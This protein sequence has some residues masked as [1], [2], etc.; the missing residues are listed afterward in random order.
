MKLARR[1]NANAVKF[2][3]KALPY[4]LVFRYPIIRV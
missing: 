3:N 4:V 1:F 2:R